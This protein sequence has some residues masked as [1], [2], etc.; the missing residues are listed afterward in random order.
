MEKSFKTLA[1]IFIALMTVPISAC[2]RD[3]PGTITGGACS[4]KELNTP[5]EAQNAIKKVDIAPKKERDLRPI[6]INQKSMRTKSENCL[7][8]LCLY[9]LFEEDMGK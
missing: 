9:Q 5:G 8:G 7:L 3:M 1:V 6:R 4:I 2:S